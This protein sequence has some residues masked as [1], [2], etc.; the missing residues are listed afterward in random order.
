MGCSSR[1]S[2]AAFWL[3]SLAVFITSC[4]PSSTSRRAGKYSTENKREKQS[5]RNKGEPS[6]TF[7]S[8]DKYENK[9][10]K[11]VKTSSI[12]AEIV[13]SAIQYSGTNYRSGGKS[14]AT[15]FDCSGFTGYIFTQ[16]GIPI[17]GPSDK[18]AQLGKQKTKENLMPGDLVFFGNRER[19]SHVAIVATNTSEEMEIVHSTTSAGVKIDKIAHSEYWQSRLLFGVDIISK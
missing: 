8:T 17:S 7:D 15:G 9:S 5:G 19:I 2:F 14:P 11:T 3:L 18:L 10:E 13:K 12:R 1:I 4:S 6:Y 16:N